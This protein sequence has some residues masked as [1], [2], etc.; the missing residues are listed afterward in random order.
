MAKTIFEQLSDTYTMQG[1]LFF[2]RS[3][4]TCQRRTPNRRVGTTTE[5][6]SEGA[7]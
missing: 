6:T 3:Y 4:S 5:A 2:A 7:P 1:D